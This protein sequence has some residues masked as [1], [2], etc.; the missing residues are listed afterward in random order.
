MENKKILK[1]MQLLKFEKERVVLQGCQLL[2]SWQ[3]F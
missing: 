2:K 3:P 1:Q